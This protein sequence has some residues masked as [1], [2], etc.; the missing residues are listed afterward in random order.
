MEKNTNLIFHDWTHQLYFSLYVN[1]Q[2]YSYTQLIAE[3]IRI[4][5]P[6]GMRS[7]TTSQT[8]REQITMALM[9][10]PSQCTHHAIECTSFD[11]Y[12]IHNNY[13]VS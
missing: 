5:S 4:A 8:L 2:S 7:T 6:E 13:M 11:T 9:V 3:D 10:T 12:H 1:D